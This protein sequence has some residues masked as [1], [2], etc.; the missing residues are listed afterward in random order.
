MEGTKRQLIVFTILSFCSII[1]C[2][3]FQLKNNQDSEQC[4]Q[5]AKN[6]IKNGDFWNAIFVVMPITRNSTD[7][8]HFRKDAFFLTGQ[9]FDTLGLIENAKYAYDSVLTMCTNGNDSIA[10]R[11]Y[12]IRINNKLYAYDSVLTAISNFERENVQYSEYIR[13]LKVI[14]LY[15]KQR[16][17]DAIKVA[18]KIDTTGQIKCDAEMY[19]GLSHLALNDTEKA[20]SQLSASVN[21]CSSSVPEACLNLGL[22]KIYGSRIRSDLFD[23]SGSV[24]PEELFMIKYESPSYDL[25]F[26]EICWAYFKKQKYDEML[27][28]IDRF[29]LAKPSSPVK[30]ELLQIYGYALMVKRKWKESMECLE[31]CYFTLQKEWSADSIKNVRKIDS[32]ESTINEYNMVINTILFSR[33]KEINDSVKNIVYENYKKIVN[34]EKLLTK[35][36]DTQTLI[37]KLSLR[38]EQLIMDVE[39]ALAKPHPIG[40]NNA[41]KPVLRKENIDSELE[42]LKKEL[43]N[44]EKKK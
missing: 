30:C 9:C 39:Y 19:S 5:L 2:V 1:A 43:E 42:E 13:L 31:K 11:E 33:N 18:G 4:L 15:K 44:L 27:A 28:N 17:S 40:R 14:A 22:L 10:F 23:S 38:K 36:Q 12:I 37:N 20:I 16:Y 26:V 32:L 29:M 34:D 8:A 24:N 6:C 35:Y 3:P 25:A 21:T 41:V 7:N